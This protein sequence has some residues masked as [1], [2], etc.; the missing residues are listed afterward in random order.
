MRLLQ[1]P[2]IP[3]VQEWQVWGQKTGTLI[4]SI[5]PFL[6]ASSASVTVDMDGAVG[7]IPFP[8]SGTIRVINADD[9]VNSAA[10]GSAATSSAYVAYTRQKRS[11]VLTLTAGVGALGADYGT[12]SLVEL[13]GTVN[14]F[15]KNSGFA[16]Q[17][18]NKHL[19]GLLYQ[20]VNAVNAYSILGA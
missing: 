6:H 20:L 3:L 12:G 7:D 4:R 14:G 11:N 19:A 9:G 16:P 10:W 1:Q 2:E 5:A 8:L 15:A 13:Q 18:D 17:P